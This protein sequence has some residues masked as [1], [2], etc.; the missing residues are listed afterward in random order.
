MVHGEGE[1][2]A[3]EA[4]ENGAYRGI[5]MGQTEDAK[6]DKNGHKINDRQFA[7]EIHID[8]AEFDIKQVQNVSQKGPQPQAGIFAKK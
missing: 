7:K 2:R 6:C 8:V 4:L 3:Q 1:N 5:K